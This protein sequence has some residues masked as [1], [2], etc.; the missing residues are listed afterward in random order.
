MLTIWH[1]C[2]LRLVRKQD[3]RT[4]AHAI[5]SLVMTAAA[6]TSCWLAMEWSS[7]LMGPMRLSVVTVSQLHGLFGQ[8]G[9]TGCLYFHNKMQIQYC[10]FSAQF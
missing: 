10:S 1:S 9:E 6:L 3:A 8:G 7:V 5:T 4:F 2:D